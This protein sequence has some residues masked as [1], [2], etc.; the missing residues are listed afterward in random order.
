[1][2]NK[3]I[4]APEI[5][6]EDGSYG[7]R[8]SFFESDLVAI[9]KWKPKANYEIPLFCTRDG[10]YT[11][12]TTLGEFTNGFPDFFSLDTGNLVNLR[13]VSRAEIGDYGGKV[14]FGEYDMHTSVN[15]S[16][17]TALPDNIKNAKKRAYDP[18]FVIGTSSGSE[19]G[20]YPAKDI[21]FVDMWD[22]KKNYHVP[23]FH[24]SNGFCVVALTM[25][26]CQEAFPYLFPAT[27]GH[28]I[29]VS[30]VSGYDEHSFGTIV[31]FEGTDYTCP[32]S[33]PKLKVL[34]KILQQR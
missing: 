18:R 16:N 8:Y 30:K 28:L 5:L 32:I 2:D 4:F 19:A 11:A 20:L 21:Y 24:H 29:N 6:S 13:N 34:K 9:E 15:K 33:Q 3:E 12:P 23:R 14:Y 31:R 22:P 26:H 25:R 1:M 17:K 10:M 7:D 27:P